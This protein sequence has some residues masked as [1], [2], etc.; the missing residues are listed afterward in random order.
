MSVFK[1]VI[2]TPNIDFRFVVQKHPYMTFLHFL[3]CF[4]SKSAL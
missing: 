1:N 3:Q 2:K 4:L